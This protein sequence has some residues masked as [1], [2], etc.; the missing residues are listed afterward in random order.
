LG[1]ELNLI[2]DHLTQTLQTLNR[3]GKTII[4]V[5]VVNPPFTRIRVPAPIPYMYFLVIKIQG[6]DMI[7]ID[8]CFSFFAVEADGS[9]IENMRKNL[10]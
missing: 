2:E 9:D 4:P 7:G 1:S 5:I 6:Y 8:I 3:K 10:A